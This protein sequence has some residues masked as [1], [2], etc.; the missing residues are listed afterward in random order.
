[1][2]DAAGV[3]EVDRSRGGLEIARRQAAR[4]RTAC[5][6]L[7]QIAAGDVLHAEVGLV[8]MAADL[9]QGHDAGMLKLRR[10]RR[11]GLETAQV[12]LVGQGAAQDHLQG[13]EPVQAHLTRLVDN[14]HPSPADF[15]QQLIIG[16]ARQDQT[17]R[18]FRNR[19]RI[20][21]P[22][23]PFS[24]NLRAIPASPFFDDG[25]LVAPDFQ[26]S[27]FRGFF[28]HQPPLPSGSRTVQFAPFALW[29][30]HGQV[31]NCHNFL[32]YV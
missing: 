5:Q 7:R 3:R 17:I 12:A 29:R 31:T 32:D 1:M 26:R 21:G 25:G 4:H 24:G 18:R 30:Q 14:P 15:C 13:H 27:R 10:R 11:L 6:P 16:K 22:I 23:M 20:T 8:F 2:N 19:G 28:G 9:E